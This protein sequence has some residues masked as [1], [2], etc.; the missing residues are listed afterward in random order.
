MQPTTS[1]ERGCYRASYFLCTGDQ[2][3]FATLMTKLCLAP[4]A[5]LAL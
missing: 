2:Q 4:P 1:N 5:L 3:T